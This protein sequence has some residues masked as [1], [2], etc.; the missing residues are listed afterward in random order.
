MYFK[1]L[2]SLK[3]T[4]KLVSFSDQIYQNYDEQQM[5]SFGIKCNNEI[6]QTLLNNRNS[7]INL[8]LLTTRLSDRIPEHD[9]EKMLNYDVVL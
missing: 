3:S 6:K 2:K 7:P 5:K 4:L 9:Y 1:Y 8:F